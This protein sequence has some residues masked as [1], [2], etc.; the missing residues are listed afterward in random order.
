MTTFN[1]TIDDLGRIELPR[2][3]RDILNTNHSGDSLTIGLELDEKGRP[4][5]SLITA[6]MKAEMPK[7]EKEETKIYTFYDD[8]SFPKVVRITKEQDKFF[9]W[10]IEQD[11]FRAEVE[12]RI[13]LP[14]IDIEDLTK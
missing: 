1:A 12:M 2:M 4:C 14:E 13:G 9:D 6:H 3:V 7:A 8:D 5:V 11:Y 10:L